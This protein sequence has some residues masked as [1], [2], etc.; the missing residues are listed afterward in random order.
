MTKFK[1]H[2]SVGTVIYAEGPT[3]FIQMKNIN[4]EFEYQSII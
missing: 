2:V 4:Q 3:F 1:I